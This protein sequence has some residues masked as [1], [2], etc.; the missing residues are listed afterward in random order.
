M[1]KEIQTT[2]PA[3]NKKYLFAALLLL[4]LSHCS[5][6]KQS[7]RVVRHEDYQR[8]TISL[9]TE[10]LKSKDADLNDKNVAKMTALFDSLCN[11]RIVVAPGKGLLLLKEEMENI[12]SLDSVLSKY[13]RDDKNTLLAISYREMKSR[14][15][16]RVQE[17][18]RED[19][20]NEDAYQ[21]LLARREQK[22]HKEGKETYV[23][24]SQTNFGD[25]LIVFKQKIHLM[26]PLIETGRE[27]SKEKTALLSEVMDLVGRMDNSDTGIK[28]RGWQAV[29]RMLKEIDIQESESDD[30]YYQRRASGLFVKKGEIVSRLESL[31]KNETNK[32]IIQYA[33][34][35][36]KDVENQLKKKP[37]KKMLA[38][39]EAFKKS[40]GLIIVEGEKSGRLDDKDSKWDATQGVDTSAAFIWYNAAYKTKDQDHKI[41]FYTKAIQLNPFYTHAYNNRG[42]AYQ[43]LNRFEEAIRDYDKAIALNPLYELAYFNRGISY[44]KLGKHDEAAEDFHKT[45]ILNPKNALAYYYRGISYS[46]A[47]KYEEAIQDYDKA[48]ELDPK[49]VLAYNS[50]GLSLSA[51]GNHDEAIQDYQKAQELDPRNAVVRKNLG[52]VYRE[53][54]N[55]DEAIREYSQ[56]IELDPQYTLAYNN[57]GISYRNLRR[58][59]EAIQDHKKAIEL[60][61][62]HPTAYYN[63]GCVY[64]ALND[65][66][67]V[68]DIWEECLKI[69]PNHEKVLEMLPKVKQLI[70]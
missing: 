4:L 65:W 11:G 47:G 26:F 34:G 32:E 49:H 30:E 8:D 51:L 16:V 20:E 59:D 2:E 22:Y 10:Q 53:L 50:R 68:I 56:A 61:P 48:I 54:G 64:W 21:R 3:M 52:D 17:R 31:R 57:R 45:I 36:M 18:M 12:S 15:L 67:A 37:D 58:Y 35:I 1:K 33:S 13:I 55:D 62:D 28:R 14:L 24:F 9:L 7:I 43:S 60:S 44:S 5:S 39:A 27:Y 70:R 69:D 38:E 23:G 46:S 25:R 63:L 19:F 40:Q 41:D 42:N 6:Q 66:K 29:Q